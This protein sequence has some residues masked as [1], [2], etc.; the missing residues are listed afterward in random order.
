[1]DK[2]LKLSRFDVQPHS[3]TASKEWNHWI[4]TM[5]WCSLSHD[6]M[7]LHSEV[8]VSFGGNCDKLQ[9]CNASPPQVQPYKLVGSLCQDCKSIPTTSR[10]YNESY[11]FH[12]RFQQ[13]KSFTYYVNQS[14]LLFVLILSMCIII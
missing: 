12:A 13:T 8:D 7:K 14:C 5:H 4:R 11:V 2:Y 9:I 1:M 6:L 10:R 3:P